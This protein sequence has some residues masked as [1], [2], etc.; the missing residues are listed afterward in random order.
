MLYSSPAKFSNGSLG[1][2][3]RDSVSCVLMQLTPKTTD[4]KIMS[5]ILQVM[6]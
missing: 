6:F 3:V 5:Q 2:S 1:T 4:Y